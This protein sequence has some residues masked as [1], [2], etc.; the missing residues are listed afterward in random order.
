MNDSPIAWMLAGGVRD[1]DALGLEWHGRASSEA[2]TSR[3]A[4]ARLPRLSIRRLRAA[5]ATPNGAVVTPTL[6]CCPA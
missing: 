1:V 2:A 5:A 3:H 6:D 4:E